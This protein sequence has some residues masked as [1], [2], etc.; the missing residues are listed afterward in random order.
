MSTFSS[1]TRWQVI[2]GI[3]LLI[4]SIDVFS[5]YWTHANL[6]LMGYAF[7][8]FPYGGIPVFSNFLGIEFSISHLTNR[9]AA[10]GILSDYQDLLL[11]ARILLICGMLSY[12]IFFNR[13]PAYRFPLALVILGAVGNIIDYFV[14][15]HVID[16][17]HFVFW[18]YDY[19]VF[20][21]ADAAVTLGI[22]WLLVVSSYQEV[23]IYSRKES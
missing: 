4:L 2:F 10:W 12:L 23:N 3:S 19:P 6:P 9:G 20:N 18:G 21:I 5:K 15:G 8:N 16:M 1:G 14:Y 7:P 22:I 13:I 17:L 11:Y